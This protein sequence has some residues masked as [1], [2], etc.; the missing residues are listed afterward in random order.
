AP[1]QNVQQ[2][3]QPQNGDIIVYVTRTGSKYH[4]DGCRYLSKSKIPMP[5]KEAAA[6]Y[7]P[8]SVCDPPRLS[9]ADSS[10]PPEK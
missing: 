3:S 7:G 6:R 8:C 4:R 1:I 2:Q 5:L 10:S 9:S